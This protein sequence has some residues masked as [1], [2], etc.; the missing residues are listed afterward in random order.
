[1]A[2]P[3]L[4]ESGFQPRKRDY[5][6]SSCLAISSRG[7]LG[8]RLHDPRW[9]LRGQPGTLLRR[10]LAGRG[11]P[12]LV[13]EVPENVLIEPTLDRGS[14]DLAAVRLVLQRLLFSHPRLIFQEGQLRKLV[15]GA[16]LV[17]LLVRNRRLHSARPCLRRPAGDALKASSPVMLHVLNP[18][19]RL[20]LRM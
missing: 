4:A 18:Q 1:M 3:R 16:V 5:L 17:A 19:P 9:H 13:L 15:K 6:Q 12:E 7:L 2:P 20:R 10:L 14:V 8:V 11:R